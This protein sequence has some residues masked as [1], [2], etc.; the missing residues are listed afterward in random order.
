MPK[1][2][3]AVNYQNSP[4]VNNNLNNI[5]QMDLAGIVNTVNY[6]FQRRERSNAI[7]NA[8]SNAQSR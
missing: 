5:F 1:N 2:S 6:S 3:P 4:L 8:I 7:S